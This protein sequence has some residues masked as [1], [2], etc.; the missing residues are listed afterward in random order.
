MAD[1]VFNVAKGRVAEMYNRVDSGD[2]ADARLYVIPISTN[3]SHATMRDCADFAAVLAAGT[4]TE[5]TANGWN[6][7]T[8]GSADL[9]ALSADH[10]NDRMDCD[11]ADQTWTTVTADAVTHLVICYGAVTSPTNSQLVPLTV[12]DFAV[13]P[14]GGDV[15]AQVAVFYRAS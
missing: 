14:S 13:T 4:T 1:S 3:S 12:H 5:R 6:R 8:L 10:A 9:A 2:P 11:F 7:K 15:V